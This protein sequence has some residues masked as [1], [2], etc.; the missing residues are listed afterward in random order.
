MTAL[1]WETLFSKVVNTLDNLP[2]AK[3][4]ETSTGNLGSEIIAANR[5]KLGRNNFRSLGG[6]GVHIDLRTDAAKILENNRMIYSCWYQLYIDS[7]YQLLIRPR[8]WEKSGR[9]PQID[10][11]VLFMFTNAGYSKKSVVW[12]LGRVV[13]ST[14][15]STSISY[16]SKPTITG[17]SPLAVI[18][19][20]PR[21]VS[22]IY[23]QVAKN[24]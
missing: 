24:V 5:I 9:L 7:I 11:I 21:D 2:I 17:P 19:R 15:R 23:A 10:N 13:A 3:C 14:T 6:D 20:N 22:V 1:Q 8:K 18:R 4:N 12:K 16:V